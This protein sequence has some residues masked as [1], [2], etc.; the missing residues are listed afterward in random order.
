MGGRQA[1][2]ERRVTR[3]GKAR[4]DRRR[5]ARGDQRR[6][7]CRELMIRM[8]LWSYTNLTDLA[9]TELRRRP[10]FISASR[11]VRPPS[12]RRSLGAARGSRSYPEVVLSIGRVLIC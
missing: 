12:R 5:G 4:G 7:G 3:K 10:W 6:A 2:H 8:T 11:R 9:D 1:L